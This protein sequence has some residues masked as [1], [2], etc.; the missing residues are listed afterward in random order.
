MSHPAPPR[1]QLKCRVAFLR[2]QP[3]SEGY[4]RRRSPLTPTCAPQLRLE[5]WRKRAPDGVQRAVGEVGARDEVERREAL[6]RMQRACALV[7]QQHTAAEV[8]C[9]EPMQPAHVCHRAVCQL[10][11]HTHTTA[12]SSAG[13]SSTRG[14]HRNE[15]GRRAHLTAAGEVEVCEVLQVP[16]GGGGG[17]RQ[18]R[19][20]RQVQL[21]EAR[22]A[23]LAQR[24]HPGVRQA[25]APAEVQRPQRRQ[26]AHIT[27]ALIRQLR[28]APA[29][30]CK[31]RGAS[32]NAQRRAF[33]SSSRSSQVVRLTRG[34][35]QLG[36]CQNSFQQKFRGDDNIAPSSTRRRR[37]W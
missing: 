11:T 4:K 5:G 10:H 33:R 29:P 34:P 14:F 1:P 37:G 28:A 16:H 17:V 18:L 13:R 35:F 26:R 9:G 22:A 15:R 24:R 36:L 12:L 8:Q 6:E 2:Y 32:F 7:R 23:M 25:L 19:A 21:R 31:P 30:P 3:S 20:A 27:H